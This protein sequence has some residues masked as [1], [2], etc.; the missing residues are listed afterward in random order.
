LEGFLAV[1]CRETLIQTTVAIPIKLKGNSIPHKGEQLTNPF[2]GVSVIQIHIAFI[3]W[4]ISQIPTVYEA[5]QNLTLAINFQK[6]VISRAVVDPQIFQKIL[7]SEQLA[8]SQEGLNFVL[9]TVAV[10]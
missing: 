4:I 5:L 1:Y 8:V 3:S 9:Y 7:V 10:S 2:S 6:L